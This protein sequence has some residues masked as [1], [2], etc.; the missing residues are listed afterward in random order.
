ME[1]SNTN[2]KRLESDEIRIAVI[3]SSDDRLRVELAG[4]QTFYSSDDISQLNRQEL[5]RHVYQIRNLNKSHLK[6]QSVMTKFD[7]SLS[8]SFSGDD[9]AAPR[10]FSLSDTQQTGGGIPL[11]SKLEV[12]TPVVQSLDPVADQFSSL[13][14]I[15]RFILMQ[16][17]SEAARV[18]ETD[19]KER[20]LREERDAE[21]R[22]KEDDREAKRREREEERKYERELY[23][24][25]EN[26]RLLEAEKKEASRVAELALERQLAAEKEN[27]RLAELAIERQLAAEKENSRLAELAIERQLAAEKEIV[28]LEQA[29]KKEAIFLAEREA[30]RKEAA[31]Q[32]EFERRHAADVAAFHAQRQTEERVEKERRREQALQRERDER[33]ERERILLEDRSIRQAERESDRLEREKDREEKYQQLKSDKQYQLERDSRFE[34]RLK[35]ASVI[36][37]ARLASQPA[38]LQVVLAR[39]KN[40]EF[41]FNSYEINNDLQIVVVTPFLNE[42]CK[43]LAMTLEKDALF[44]QLRKLILNEYNFSPKLLRKSFL[45]MFKMADE[46]VSQFT[47]RLSNG[48]QMYLDSRHVNSSYSS[49][50]DLLISDRVKDSL[51]YACRCHVTDRESQDSWLPSRKIAEVADRY[52]SE[53]DPVKT[54]SAQP[55]FQSYYSNNNKASYANNK[56]TVSSTGNGGGGPHG[57]VRANKDKIVC[58]FCHKP[59]HVKSQCFRLNKDG[60]PNTNT[61]TRKENSDTTRKCYVCNSSTHLANRCPDRNLIW[62]KRYLGHR[63]YLLCRFQL[64]IPRLK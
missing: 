46:S 10:S 58:F 29:A 16:A 63:R 3:K 2:V 11:V 22:Q 31:E 61:N 49:I 30:D 54:N 19:R 57:Y 14:A 50:F 6:C 24:R 5:L 45:E 38:D 35:R 21:R 60:K 17:N 48:L 18:A 26:S 33:S 51:S 40:V 59:G 43:K 23:E 64:W 7:P 9:S 25:K 1:A 55:S 20:L 53:R 12:S 27:S 42:R 39:F 47:T 4:S 52:L 62:V 44:E 13:S 28:R 34:L 32:R 8:N 36:A 15:E 37:H 56:T 41:I